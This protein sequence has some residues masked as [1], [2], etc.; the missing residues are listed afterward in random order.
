MIT[1]VKSD[2]LCN[3]ELD[4]RDSIF[5]TSVE[6]ICLVVGIF[7]VAGG[8]AAHFLLPG[9][10][11]GYLQAAAIMTSPPL[12]FLGLARPG[13]KFVMRQCTLLFDKGVVLV[14]DKI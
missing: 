7:F 1:P 4:S 8:L 6:K 9:A 13:A 12:L 5:T 2:R 3:W 14:E 10:L 11:S